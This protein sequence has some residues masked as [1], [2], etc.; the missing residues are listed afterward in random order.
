MYFPSIL[1]TFRLEFFTDLIN[2]LSE[3]FVSRSIKKPVRNAEHFL[4]N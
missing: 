4:T 1:A 3:T 2:C